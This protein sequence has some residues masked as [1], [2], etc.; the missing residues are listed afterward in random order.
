[1]REPL[2][3]QRWKLAKTRPPK[4]GD[5][6]REAG[7]PNLMEQSAAISV[8]SDEREVGASAVTSVA[9]IFVGRERTH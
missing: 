6:L 4:P 5:W 2:V 9:D 1:M 8:A 7:P 3:R